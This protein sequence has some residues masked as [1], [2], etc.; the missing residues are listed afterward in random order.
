[1]LTKDKDLQRKSDLSL[2]KHNAFLHNKE[3]KLIYFYVTANISLRIFVV[4]LR[5]IYPCDKS[6]MELRYIAA[7]GNLE[8]CRKDNMGER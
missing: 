5:G 7:L 2:Q 1:M 4:I 8:R 3:G 6:R